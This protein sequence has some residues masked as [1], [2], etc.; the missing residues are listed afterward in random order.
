MLKRSQRKLRSSCSRAF[1]SVEPPTLKEL[2]AQA[3]PVGPASSLS[4]EAQINGSRFHG[5]KPPDY[6]VKTEQPWHKAAAYLFATG[7]ASTKDVAEACNKSEPTVRN[8][9]RQPWFQE[10]VTQLMAAS[11]SRDILSLLKAEQINSLLVMIDL[12]DDLKTPAPVRS[13]VCKNILDRTLGK[14]ITRIES[15]DKTPHSD[16]PVAE[17]RQLREELVRSKEKL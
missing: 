7:Q 3:P 10:R 13:D 9:L 15:E 14:P 12:R 2:K 16:D 11:G 1:Q 17:A 4:I 6:D 8:L 5:S